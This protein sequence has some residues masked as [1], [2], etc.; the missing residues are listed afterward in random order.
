MSFSRES[1]TPS[2]SAPV[3]GHEIEAEADRSPRARAMVAWT[4]TEKTASVQ[5]QFRAQAQYLVDE[6]FALALC[7]SL[8]ADGEVVEHRITLGWRGAPRSRIG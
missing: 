3:P 7:R 2:A 8:K 6:N 1:A 4:D 5:M